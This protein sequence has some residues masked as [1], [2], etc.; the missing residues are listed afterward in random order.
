MYSQP[1]TLLSTY[2]T[3]NNQWIK[4]GIKGDTKGQLGYVHKAVIAAVRSKYKQEGRTR[5]LSGEEEGW[6]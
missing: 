3:I 2:Q 4:K 5:A 1:S 6:D